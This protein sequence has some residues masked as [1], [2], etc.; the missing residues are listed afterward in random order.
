MFANEGR[1]FESEAK[2]QAISPRLR[3]ALICLWAA[4]LISIPIWV[5]LA[6]HG[7]DLNVYRAAASSLRNAHDPYADSIAIQTE[8]YRHHE[9]RQDVDPPYCYVYSPIT[10][11]LLKLISIVPDWISA[12]VYWALYVGGVLVGIRVAMAF[13]RFSERKIF[14]FFAPISAFFPGLLNDGTILGG[15]IAYILYGFILLS[16]LHGWRRKQW[17]WFYFAVLA[18][19]CF[20]LPFLSFLLLP[21]LSERRQWLSAIFAGLIGAI[22]F[23]SQ[24]L[25]KPVLFKHFLQAVEQQFSYNRDFGASPSGILARFLIDHHYSYSPASLIFYLC[26]AVL[27]IFA[28]F[29]GARL[30]FNGLIDLEQWAPMLLVGV[31]LLNPRLQ[32]YDS[33]AITLP[34]TLIGWRSLRS[35][36]SPFRTAIAFGGVFVAANLI[37]RISWSARNLVECVLVIAIS[38]AG[39]VYIRRQSVDSLLEAELDLK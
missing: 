32:T 28:L 18:A 3:I 14:L 36:L 38:L 23:F 30:Y 31:V 11:L 29:Y 33:S 25:V 37:S 22:L 10:L 21:P 35:T 19:S 16:A 27:L 5:S 8:F 17:F 6:D 24:S 7:W 26:Y 39:W 12:I 1:V 2:E 13:V 4:T 9:F 15:N 34:L 20:K